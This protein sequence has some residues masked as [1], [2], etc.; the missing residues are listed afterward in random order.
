MFHSKKRKIA[1]VAT[2][3][4]I[5]L[6]VISLIFIGIGE[7]G[8]L[9]SFIK[10]VLLQGLGIAIAVTAA[11]FFFLRVT[12]RLHSKPMAIAMGV[13]V[14]GVLA[15]AYA[16]GALPTTIQFPAYKQT[17]GPGHGPDLPLKNVY[18]FFRHLDDFDRVDEIA[19][20]PNDVPSPLVWEESVDVLDSEEGTTTV[21][22]IE[23]ESEVVEIF[24][25][26]KEVLSEMG[27][28]ITFNYWTF[29]GQVP[30]PML[31]VKE[32]DTVKLTITNNPSSLHNHNI[33]LHAVTGPGGGASVTSVAPGETKSF[34]FKALNPGLYVYHCAVANV[35]SHMAHG[36]Y[37][38]ILVEPEGGLPEVDKEFYVMQGEFYSTGKIGQKGLQVFDTQAMLDGN[39]DYVVFNGRTGGITGKMKAE[40]GDTVRIFFGNGGV[41]LISSFHVIGEIFDRVYPEGAIGGELHKNVQTTTVPAGGATIVEFDVEYPGNYI[42]VDH[43]LARLDKGGWGVLEVT[44]EKDDEIFSSDSSEH[45]HASH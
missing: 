4:G 26:T 43:A 25:E 3:V 22:M 8:E 9:F 16:A 45:D 19:R 42:L 17:F 36:M 35:P 7:I 29:D 28:E 6:V 38:M 10:Y 15:V 39:P 2:G 14:L 18:Q 24:L 30:G 23:H 13:F 5:S 31:R 12:W 21:E 41:N 1:V 44:G 34:T 27:P 20:D 11:I 37:G 33:D 32:G 40:V